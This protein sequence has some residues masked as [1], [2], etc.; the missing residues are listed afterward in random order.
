MPIIAT[1]WG[2]DTC[3]CVLRFTIDTAERADPKTKT[4]DRVIRRCQVH[5]KI[6]DD[7]ELL[8]VIDRE[9]K[10]KNCVYR[11]LPQVDAA[12]A[13]SCRTADGAEY[14]DLK[15]GLEYEYE[16]EGE[17]SSRLLHVRVAGTELSSSRKS[18]VQDWCD[19]NLGRDRVKV[20]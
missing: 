8:S 18:A 12:L 9:N 1:T 3:G 15:A 20:D 5:E 13:E 7:K 16:F 19:T 10:D 6:T 2:P 11:A 14:V 4:I 17:G